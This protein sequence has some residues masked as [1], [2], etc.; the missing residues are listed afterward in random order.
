MP[1]A[2]KPRFE[3]SSTYSRDFGIQG[4]DPMLRATT[5]PAEVTLTATTH[6]LNEGTTRAVKHPPGY[7]GFIP[8]ANINETAVQQASGE[9]VKQNIKACVSI[10]QLV[11]GTCQ[12]HDIVCMLR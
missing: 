12:V 1:S 5:N 11:A 9:N 2:G 10:W 4:S 3:A 6:D 7:T 8:A